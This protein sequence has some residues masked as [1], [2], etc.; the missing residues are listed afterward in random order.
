M[1]LHVF[2]PSALALCLLAA[3]AGAALT[4][5]TTWVN[6]PGT[7]VK[8]TWSSVVSY[9][10]AT[11]SESFSGE[12]W[13]VTLDWKPLSGGIAQGG[14]TGGALGSLIA[15]N[16]GAMTER[17]KTNVYYASA[18]ANHLAKT[19]YI[20][21]E[22]LSVAFDSNTSWDFSTSS[23][24]TNLESFYATAIHEV[25]HGLGFISADVK[26]GGWDSGTGPRIFD[27][28]LGLGSSSPVSLI[29]MTDAELAA[30]FVSNNVFWTGS[31]AIAG[32]GGNPVQIYA[33][34]P[35]YQDGSSMSHLDYTVDTNTSLLMYPADAENLPLAYSY[36]ATEIGMWKDMGYDVVPEP[37]TIWLLL[38]GAGVLWKARR[39]L[40]S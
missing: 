2:L 6:D 12:T 38:L 4:I 25:A 3:N 24:A 27:Y 39:S 36:S 9:Y 40:A 5:N 37:G 34:S 8:S 18:L 31:N 29:G 33:P 35:T 13:N 1:K 23:K 10:Q 22:N 17:I 26:T 14:P 19:N 30:A 15:T 21:G 28:Y 7:D 16:T 32:H 11:F 20:A